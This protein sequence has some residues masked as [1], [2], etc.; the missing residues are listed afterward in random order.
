MK[1]LLILSGLGV[2]S[3]ILEIINLRKLI[4]PIIMLGLIA[5][6]SVCIFDFNK[7]EDVYSMLFVDNSAL[8]ITIILCFTTLCW[9]AMNLDE[10]KQNEKII[11]DFST[12][13]MFSLAGAYI[14]STYINFT[15]MF[16][17]VEILSIPMY[18]LAGSNR[19]NIYSNEAAYKYLIMGAFASSFLL[20]GIAFIYGSTATFDIRQIVMSTMSPKLN[21]QLYMVGVLLVLFALAFKVAV[22]P[23]HFWAPDVYSGTPTQITAYMS[24]VVKV[25]AIAAFFRLFVMAFGMISPVFKDIVL[26]LGILSVVFGNL[27]AVG[28]S[29]VKRMLAYSGI[30]HAGFMFLAISVVNKQTTNATLYY[31]ASYALSGI[32]LFWVVV[33]MNKLKLATISDYNGL[34]QRNGLLTFTLVLSLLSMA[35]IPPLAGFIAKYNVLIQIFSVK[36]ISVALLAIFGSLV[37]VY[38]YFKLIISSVQNSDTE[39]NPEKIQLSILSKIFLILLNLSIILLGIFSNIIIKYT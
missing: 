39:T 34:I 23:F 31:M 9:F 30:S 22:I 24:T 12:L 8:I 28:Q 37:A 16:L 2:A 36:N 21:V 3:L 35:G 7:P 11:A 15:M 25:A 27:L 18:I 13:I 38:Y 29:N 5:C 17:G 20:L 4:L 26:L 32:A 19:K 6:I 1:E 33:E 10:F 14:L